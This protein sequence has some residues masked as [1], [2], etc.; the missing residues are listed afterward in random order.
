M[1]LYKS[2]SY[3]ELTGGGGCSSCNEYASIYNLNGQLIFKGYYNKDTTIEY[4][5]NPNFPNI[6]MKNHRKKFKAIVIK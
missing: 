1:F 4:M 2:K 3:F 6:E 5:S